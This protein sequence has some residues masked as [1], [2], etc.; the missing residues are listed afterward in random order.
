MA[1]NHV[2]FEPPKS[3]LSI[4]EEDKD[5]S[6][7]ALTK[8]GCTLGPQSRTVEVLEDLLRAGMTVARFDFSWG[9]MEYHQETLDNL[10]IAMRNTKRLCCT[11]LDTMGPEIIV[12]NRPEAPISLTAGQTLTLTCNKSVAASETVLPI[13][14]PSLAGT[15][16]A[17]GSQVFVGQYLFTGSETSSVYLTVQEVKGDEAVCTCNNT[18]ILE[19]LALT[20]HIAHMRNE[21]PILAD[22]D[23][24]AIRQWGAANKIDYVCLSFTRNAADIGVVRAVLD[25]CGLEQTRVMAKIENLEGLVH[26]GDIVEAADS[27]LLSR[28][29][30]GICLDAEKMFLA[31]KKL[32]RACN[33]AGKPVMVTRVVDTMTD[34]P[35][36]TRA[37][38][39]DVANLV[40]DGADGILLG[41]ETFRGKYAVSTV[42]TVCAICKQAELCFDNQSYYRS[43]M[44]YFGCYTLHP[45]LGKREALASSAVRAAAK[46]NAALIIVFTVTG[47]TAR[48]VAK[49]KP[50][51]PILTVVTSAH[52]AKAHNNDRYSLSG[53]GVNL[54]AAGEGG[55][56]ASNPVVC[57]DIKSDGLKWT[58]L[59]EVQARQCMLYRGVL[60]I[61]ADPDF[62]LPGG[63]ILDYAIAYAKQVGMVRSGDKVVVS[64]CPRT[65]YSDVMEEA[66]VVKLITVDDHVIPGSAMTFNHPLFVIGSMETLN[67]QND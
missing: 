10:R 61:M 2:F 17:P 66:G 18:C 40:L 67:K 31:Q 60:P 43:L 24:S 45:N 20:V 39:T 51:C 1:T 52:E 14:Y 30:L 41:S 38:A 35:R 65:G 28:G 62:S 16:L 37:E 7:P 48:L 44:E 64:Q 27:V 21:A 5:L 23:M 4:L 42:K 15:G 12:L 9:S 34:A 25:S 46:I 58:L 22:S 36:P 8:L 50:A 49:Y 57:P 29:N 56:E 3:L 54:V 33:L 6:V 11:M 19:G 13:S 53:S 59:G 32:L 47:Q 26:A 55:E 63:A